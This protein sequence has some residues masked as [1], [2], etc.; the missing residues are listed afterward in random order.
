MLNTARDQKY[1]YREKNTVQPF[2]ANLHSLDVTL[3]SKQ[4]EAEYE[5]THCAL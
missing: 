4:I 3:V 1:L 2:V 5:T